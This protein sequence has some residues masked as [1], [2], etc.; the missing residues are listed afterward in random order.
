V[1][2]EANFILI[3]RSRMQDPLVSQILPRLGC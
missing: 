2:F 3:G 1:D